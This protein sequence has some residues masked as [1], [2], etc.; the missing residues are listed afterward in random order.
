MQMFAI[1]GILLVLGAGA[2]YL[3]RLQSAGAET[4]RV[5]SALE[6]TQASLEAERASH[7][8]EIANRKVIADERAEQDVRHRELQDELATV[9]SS[10]QPGERCHPGCIL[11]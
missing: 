11:P 10:I 4:D 5:V 1:L 2:T 9:R 7:A 3:G 8:R 6:T